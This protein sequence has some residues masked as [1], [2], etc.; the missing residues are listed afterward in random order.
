[1]IFTEARFLFFFILVFGV[2]WAVDHLRFRKIWLLVASYAFYAAWDWRFLGLIIGS[3]VLDYFVGLKLE[4]AVHPKRVV[5][6]SVVAN[7]GALG[8]FKYFNFFLESGHSFFSWMGLDVSMPVL[9]II[10]PVGI[11]F[12]T[13]QTMSYSLDIYYKKMA[14]V[15]DFWDLA[16]F[17]AFFPQLVAG[18][19][20]RARDF[21]PQLAEKKSFGQVM[22]RRACMLFF[23]GYFKK[24][25]LSDAL[26]STYA[27]Q[28]F[29]E[30]EKYDAFS[31]FLGVMCYTVQIYCDF[32]G[33]S[34][35]AIAC[36]A[37]LGFSL[38]DNFNH[39]YLASNITSFWRRWHMSLSSW[40]R[41]Y[42]YIGLGGNRGGALFTS[43]NLMLT[44]LLGGLW[45]GAGWNFVIWGGLHGL[46]LMIHKAWAG[47]AGDR[48]PGLRTVLGWPIT[49]YFVSVLWIFFRSET[50]EK[51]W[52]ICKSY[53]LWDTEGARQLPTRLIWV[54]TGL[55]AVH[56][57][58]RK[59]W[60][61]PLI[62]R[63]PNWAFAVLMGVLSALA[64]H[65]AATNTQ[66]F[67]YFQF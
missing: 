54:L 32:S 5:W 2:Y 21:L 44:M 40:L 34:D 3:T 67:I 49:L 42:L 4:N 60:V 9:S 27:D 66:P 10:L 62:K 57:I 48:Q 38:C 1:M 47:L 33:Y 37:L 65:F 56:F 31:S 43:R 16:L 59:G 36:A 11:S 14:P 35:M 30:P 22:V 46:A 29:A 8:F 15:R 13:F 41:D 19:I 23:I 28:F 64:L 24:M 20:V 39:P 26:L 55:L 53:I 51:A 45:H 12:Y 58:A 25:C 63:L 61:Q 50:F 6:V 17:V 7:L 18:P 52:L